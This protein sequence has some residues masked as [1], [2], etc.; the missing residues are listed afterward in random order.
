MD[1]D[2]AS[3]G[4]VATLVGFDVSRAPPLGP[5]AGVDAWLEDASDANKAALPALIGPGAPARVNDFAV[6]VGAVVVIGD[7]ACPDAGAAAVAPGDDFRGATAAD[8]GDAGVAADNACANELG[9]SALGG[10][11]A[12]LPTGA[13]ETGVTETEATAVAACGVVMRGGGGAIVIKRFMQIP[14]Q[15]SVAT[16]PPF[17]RGK[18]PKITP[19]PGKKCRAHSAHS[20]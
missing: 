1:I 2:A 8:A 13:A 11:D 17:P 20:A 12:L 9:V 16:A 6:D 14:C 3:P 7:A 18:S 10:V 4:F 5:L 15:T 19:R